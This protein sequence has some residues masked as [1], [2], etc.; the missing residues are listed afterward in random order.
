MM[1]QFFIIS[2]QF[3]LRFDIQRGG[4]Y[5]MRAGTARVASIFV[6]RTRLGRLAHAHA[7]VS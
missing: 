6:V 4:W 1:E 2:V 5:L 3:L 7:R